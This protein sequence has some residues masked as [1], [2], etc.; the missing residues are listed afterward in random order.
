LKIDEVDIFPLRIPFKELAQ[1]AS[2]S[3]SYNESI[4]VRVRAEG[5]IGWGEA[6]TDP[7][8]TGETVGSIIC[9]IKEYF[10][11]MLLGLEFASIEEV[12]QKMDEVLVRNTAA[13]AAIDTACFDLMGKVAKIPVYACLGGKF[14]DEIFE[15]PEILFGPINHVVNHCKKM[16]KRGVKCLK[17]KTGEGIDKDVEKVKRIREAVG[18]QIEIRLDANQGWKNYWKALSIIKRIEKCDVSIIE[19]PL[20]TRDLYGTARLRRAVNIPIM[21][22][23]S[24]HSINDVLTAISLD[25]CDLISVKVMKAGG[26]LRIKEVVELCSIYG[27]PCHM[28]T[29]WESEVGWAANLHLITGLRGIQ[30]WDAY[31]PTEIYWGFSTGVGSPIKS[32]LKNGVRVVELPKGSGL[33]VVVNVNTIRRYLM[34]KPIYI[35]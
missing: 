1:I 10:A 26:L 2:S 12:H 20:P 23:E 13:K 19:Q 35:K 28:G 24:V 14:N 17:V 7:V 15:V 29:S 18:D 21:L 3:F 25:A 8:F 32:T 27:I 30:L 6:M 34:N 5:M 33:G 22:D 11:P 9:A 4:L 31:S 16:V